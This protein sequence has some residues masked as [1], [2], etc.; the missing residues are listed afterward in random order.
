MLETEQNYRKMSTKVSGQMN[1]MLEN[2]G[3]MLEK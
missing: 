3:K 2:A 1:K